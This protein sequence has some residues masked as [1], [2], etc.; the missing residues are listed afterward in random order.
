MGMFIYKG[1]SEEV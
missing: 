1:V